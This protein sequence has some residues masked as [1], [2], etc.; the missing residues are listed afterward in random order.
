MKITI[1]YDNNAR[2]GLKKGW[3][4]SCLIE[5]DKKILFDTGDDSEALLFN[6]EKLNIKLN[7]I[8]IIVLSHEHWDHAGGLQGLLKYIPKVRVIKPAEFSEIN[9]ITDTDVNTLLKTFRFGSFKLTFN[10]SS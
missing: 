2:E 10:L 5:D 8:D 7:E 3:G 6:M 9:K 4:F 1:V